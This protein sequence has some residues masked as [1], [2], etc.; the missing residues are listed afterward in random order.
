MEPY[1]SFETRSRVKR[2][3]TSNEQHGLLWNAWP[4]IWQIV[5]TYGTK[6]KFRGKH[7]FLLADFIYLFAVPRAKR[8]TIHCCQRIR[9]HLCEW[10]KP[11]TL[12]CKIGSY[13]RSTGMT[14]QMGRGN[15]SK[16][17]GK[18]QEFPLESMIIIPSGIIIITVG[19]EMSEVRRRTYGWI[20][21]MRSASRFLSFSP[22]CNCLISIS[23]NAQSLFFS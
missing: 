7:E 17:D 13:L 18:I 4:N 12:C 20:I 3:T 14:L 5:K 11:N 15:Q 8:E 19:W 22:L 16:Y 23:Q 9:Q 21:F 6:S 10:V 1:H 2:H